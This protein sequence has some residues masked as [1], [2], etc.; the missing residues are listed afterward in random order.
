MDG[1]PGQIKYVDCPLCG[2]R[3]KLTCGRDFKFHGACSGCG[4]AIQD[5]G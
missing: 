4:K 3:V 2:E 5:E 1:Y